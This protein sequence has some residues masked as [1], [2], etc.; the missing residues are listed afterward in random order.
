MTLVM[1]TLQSSKY[2]T[3]R[4]IEKVGEELL[5]FFSVASVVFIFVD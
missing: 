1:N 2:K 3:T 4:I 5:G